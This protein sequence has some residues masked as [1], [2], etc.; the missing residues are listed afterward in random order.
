MAN[1]AHQQRSHTS[2]KKK[3]DRATLKVTIAST[4]VAIAA[5]G[6]AFWSGY[7]ARQTRLDLERPFVSV[8]P[9]NEDDS[10]PPKALPGP[11]LPTRLLAFDKSA[12]HNIVVKCKTAIDTLQQWTADEIRSP[13]HTFP[14]MLP[15][16]F[17]FIQC[18]A[19][20]AFKPTPNTA[21]VQLGT[22]EYEDNR[23][24]HFLTPFCFRYAY[25]PGVV[26]DVAQ[27]G[28]TRGLPDLK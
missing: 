26:I 9:R 23:G 21:I 5:A 27:C 24:E 17:N 7:E 6:A 3:I 16:H 14:Y 8:D 11:I 10:N 19:D 1:G 25:T 20:A 12:A 22:V 2:V 28:D 15:T 4:I 18:P 13:T